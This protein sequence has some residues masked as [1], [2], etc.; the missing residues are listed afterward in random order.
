MGNDGDESTMTGK[1]KVVITDLISSSLAPEQGVLGEL[2]DVVAL[3]SQEEDDLLGR[4]EDA[5]AIILYHT[6]RISRKT[7]DRLTACK[8]IVRGGWATTTLTIGW[9]GNAE[10]R[11]PTC[12]TTAAR[13]WPTPPSPF[14]WR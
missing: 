13:K 12:P 5:D 9:R 10:F 1:Y 11:W 2:A 14:C 4:I 6:I 3:D 7:I 8:L